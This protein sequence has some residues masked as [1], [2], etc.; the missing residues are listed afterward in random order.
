MNKIFYNPE[1]LEIKG[2]SDGAITMEFPFLET[3]Y[4]IL[5]LNETFKVVLENDVLTL[6]VKE[7][8]TDEEWSKLV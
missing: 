5:L 8:F 4:P 7:S 3:Q 6:K 2:A 1:T